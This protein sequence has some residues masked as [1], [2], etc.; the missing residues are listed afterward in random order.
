MAAWGDSLVGIRRSRILRRLWSPRIDSKES[1]P[2]A[3]GAWRAGTITL[4]SY[5]VPSPP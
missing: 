2:P 5:S 4:Y 3:Y 1:I